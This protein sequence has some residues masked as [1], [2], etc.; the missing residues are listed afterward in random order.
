MLV[1]MAPLN[2]CREEDA[3]KVSP[4]RPVRTQDVEFTEWKQAGSAIG[5]IKPRYE[6]DVGFRIAGKVAARFVEIGTVVEKGT[7]IARMDST[8]EQTAIAVAETEI[9]SARAELEDATGQEGR[10]R[11]L[12]RRG[13]TTQVNYDAAQRRFKLANAK[14]ESTELARKDALDRLGYTELRSDDAGI[15][16]AVA[17]Q[18][19]QV[20]AAGQMVV[21]IARTDVKEAEFKIAEYTLRSVPRDSIVEVSLVDD[22]S[23]KAVGHVREVAT[24]ADAIT[25]SFAVR[26][27][28]ETPPAAMRFGATVQGRVV[29]E[30]KQVV[31]LASSA[32]VR[33][34]D[35]PAVWVFDPISSTVSLRHV[36]I[37][38]Y[39]VDQILIVDGL[40]R[41]ERVVTKGIQKLWPGMKVRLL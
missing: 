37:L 13:Y 22:P 4:I 33:A 27:T 16:T 17:A 28:L 7:I 14:L 34:E 23:I 1:L 18:P 39:E 30:E 20:I 25:R 12:L 5:E 24:T 9:R 32:L 38:R 29:L 11:E 3:A 8:N 15:V 35:G 26:V 6:S 41:G 2:A 10:Q 36:T 40:K 31:R 21:R 19:G